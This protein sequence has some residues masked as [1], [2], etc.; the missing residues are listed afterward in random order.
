MQKPNEQL[1]DFDHFMILVASTCRKYGLN[2]SDYKEPT[3]CFLAIIDKAPLKALLKV[4]AFLEDAYKAE[5]SFGVIHR[6][7][8]DRIQV[9]ER[10]QRVVGLEG[11][12]SA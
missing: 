4:D 10:A 8:R 1:V 12:R 7:V 5:D 2:W 6:A 11:V 9:L 3:E